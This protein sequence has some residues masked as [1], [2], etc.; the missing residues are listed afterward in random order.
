MKAAIKFA[1]VIMAV[2]PLKASGALVPSGH[3]FFAEEQVQE[4]RLYFEQDDYWDILTDNYEDEI[5]L[6][7]G[8]IWEDYDLP[9]V[10]VRFK[11]GSSYLHN[12]TMK[13]SFKIDFDEFTQDQN[14]QGI[15]KI[16]LNC[17]YDDPSFVRERA[18][19]EIATAAGLP[20]PRTAFTALYINDTY[21]GLYTLV[22]QFDKHFIQERFG[23]T[24][25]GN[26]WKGDNHGTLEFLDWDR[27]SYYGSYELKTNES[28]NDWTSLIE[29]TYLLNNTSVVE[30]PDTLSSVMDI[31]TALALL[32]VDNLLVNLDSYSGRCANYYLYCPDRD[33]RFVFG[34]WDMNESWG[35]FNMWGYS[36]TDLQ[37]LSPYWTNIQPAESRPLADVLWSVDQYS[38]VYEGHLKKLMATVSDPAVLLPRMEDMRDLIREW[39]YLEEPPMSL[40]TPDQ[41]EDAMYFNVPIGPGRS[42]PAL[43]T[44]IENR[45]SY[46][47]SLLGS[48]EPVNDLILNEMMAGNDSTLADSD[49]EYEDWIEITNTGT[50][51]IDLS[52][53]HLTDDMA[54]P[55]KYSFPDTII[56]PGEYMIIWADK[57]TDQ[58]SLHA[59]FKLDK[60]G[61][62]VYLMQGYVIVDWI[63]FPDIDDDVS[64]GRYPDAGEDWM[65]Q[66]YPTPGAP[67]TNTEPEEEGDPPA[68]ATLK[69]LS[70]N[71]IYAGTTEITL[72]G[73]S[74]IAAFHIYDLSGRLVSAPFQGSLNNLQTLLVDTSE[75]STG[76][77]ILRLAQEQNVTSVL[78]S[79]IR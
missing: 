36:I 70:P 78:I 27:E 38:L 33:D 49:G 32:A 26:L 14:I 2:F 71:P 19:Y 25:D 60:D 48:W 65:F 1:L 57:D 77:Y 55:R 7:A 43:A 59:E 37:E 54:F 76:I 9:S 28:A 61:E 62:E 68:P 39:V 4:I 73:G 51:S 46:L 63:S 18:A 56:Q 44:F 5:Y 20:C 52:E 40:F 21:W 35:C 75:F 12:N 41:F 23:E 31:N 64:W 6:S 72:S 67:N 47:T 69:I 79:V 24:E 10:G 8:F 58:G 53:Y 45:H 50:E 3:A 66:A 17:N 30:L 13:K 22:E 15:Y 34:E 16:N 74:G 11:G 42:A 29:L